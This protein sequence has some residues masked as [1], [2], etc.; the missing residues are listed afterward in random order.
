MVE[1]HPD[2]NGGYG[3]TNLA[4]RY[5]LSLGYTSQQELRVSTN[6]KTSFIRV[7]RIHSGNQTWL[8]GHSS[9]QLDDVPINDTGTTRWCPIIS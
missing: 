3:Y 9:I 7:F 2:P 8:A 1:M 6:L 5:L 4:Y